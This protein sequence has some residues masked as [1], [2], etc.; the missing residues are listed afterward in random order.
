MKNT[1]LRR[2]SAVLVLALVAGC[3]PPKYATYESINKDFSASVPWGWQVMT[4]QQDYDFAQATFIGPFDGDFYLGAPSLSVRCRSI[5]TRT[6]RPA[7]RPDHDGDDDRRRH[8][9]TDPPC[10]RRPFGRIQGRSLGGFGVDGAI[11][12]Q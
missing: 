7:H 1:L 11:R 3:S 6:T 5:G 12:F 2:L 10:I 4:D 9:A 8:D